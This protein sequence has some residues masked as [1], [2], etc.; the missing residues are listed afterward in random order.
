M[1]PVE[2]KNCQCPLSLFVQVFLCHLSERQETI[3]P[4]V[5]PCVFFPF[6]KMKP[7]CLFIGEV[8]ATAKRMHKARLSIIHDKPIPLPIY[9]MRT[10]KVTQLKFPLKLKAVGLQ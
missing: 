6:R 5:A 3:I 1:S 8:W 4:R 9:N 10:Q 2:S 7:F